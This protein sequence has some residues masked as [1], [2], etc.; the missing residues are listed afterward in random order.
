MD[1]NGD[2]QNDLIV[3]SPYRDYSGFTDRGMVY[4]Y[5]GTASTALSLIPSASIRALSIPEGFMLID[6]DNA[7]FM[8]R[9]G[10]QSPPRQTRKML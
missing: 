3:G 10:V 8:R 5:Y 9:N 2:S 6:I 7:K 4:A 1:F